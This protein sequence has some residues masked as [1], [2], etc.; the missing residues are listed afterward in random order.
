MQHVAID[1][2]GRESQLCARATDG[3]IVKEARVLTKTLPKLLE[4]MEPSRV[5]LETSA[6]A[7]L[8]ADVALAHGH[9]VRVV[10]AT[11]VKQ[12]GVGARGIKT[13]RRDAQAL[14]EVSCRIDLPSV[15]IP[16]QL[17]R[18]LKSVCGSREILVKTRTTVINNVRGWTRTQLVR[19]RT[20]STPT[21][22]E[23]VRE[24]A[25][26]NLL[27]LPEHINRQLAVLDTL[28]VQIKAA[29][30]QLV[31]LAD[32]HPVCRK[33]M[34]TPGVGPVTA[35]RYVAAL[36]D[37]TRF[38]NAHAVQSYLGLTPGE[39]SSSERKQHTGITKAGAMEVR[40][41]LIQAAWAAFRKAPQEPMVRWAAQIAERRGVFIAI[42]ALAR[43]LAGILFAMWRD[44]T[45]YRPSESAEVAPA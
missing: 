7:F 19:I 20:G 9:Q 36:D 6:E 39:S 42:V 37:V 5:I 8:I 16:S 27:A 43:K 29:D 33:L 24:Y 35:V 4:T 15:H 1:L 38:R 25:E 30:Q 31:K 13:D 41:A 12:L 21:F 10:P 17:A 2:G 26:A 22:Q 45:T 23:R 14:S 34:T 28:K 32:E 3:S 40:R 11:L 44:G 18:E